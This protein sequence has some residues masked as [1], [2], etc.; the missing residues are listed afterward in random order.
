MSPSLLFTNGPQPPLQA[1]KLRTIRHRENKRRYRA[2]QREYVESLEQRLSDSRDQQVAGI[3]EVQQAAQKVVN[4]NSRLR[5]L[6]RF[7][8]VDDAVVESWLR[9][10][11]TTVTLPPPRPPIRDESSSC[12][13]I[14][15][16]ST[17]RNVRLKTQASSPSNS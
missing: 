9:G 13:I 8:G 2:R 11:E 17:L 5:S 16:P 7:I 1:K 14:S 6:L 4:D 10:I 12:S 3:K 15:K